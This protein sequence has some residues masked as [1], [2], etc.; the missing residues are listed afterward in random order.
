[1]IRRPWIPIT[2]ACLCCG[3][4]VEAVHL[5]PVSPAPQALTAPSI[6]SGNVVSAPQG[7]A[8][9]SFKSPDGEKFSGDCAIGSAA[10]VNSP[11]KEPWDSVFGQGDYVAHVVGSLQHC[12]ATL[13][14][15]R[16]TTLS[17]EFYRESANAAVKGIARDAGGLVYKLGT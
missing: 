14:G 6:L 2:L 8:S 4:A 15:S 11:L 10:G 9:V 13:A 17:L 5:Y 7:A 16:G 3:C 1:M 12:S